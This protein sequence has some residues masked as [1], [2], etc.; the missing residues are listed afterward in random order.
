MENYICQLLLRYGHPA[1]RKPQQSPHQHHEIIYGA[2]IQNPIEEYTFPPLDASGIKHIQ[3]IF[4]TVLYHYRAVNKTF[5][6]TIS[7][8][9]SEQASAPQATTKAASHLLDYL[10]TYPNYGITYRSSNIILAAHS[11][12]AYLNETCSRSRA[13]LHI[14]YSYND[15]IPRDNGPIMSLS[16]IINVVMSSASEAELSGLFITAKAMVPL[17]NT[18]KEMK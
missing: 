5:L 7:S 4:S 6:T 3:G 15:P 8:I 13:R 14:F 9:G 17:R 2:R 10:A 16:Q 1:P 18:L 11:D 12:A